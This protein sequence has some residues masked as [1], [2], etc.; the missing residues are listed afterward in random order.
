LSGERGRAY[1]LLMSEP[2]PEPRAYC[3][4]CDALM[5]VERPH[6]GIVF[7][8]RV[9]IGLVAIC[10]IFAPLFIADMVLMLPLMSG[11]ALAGPTLARLAGEPTRCK[12]C[13][14]DLDVYGASASW[15]AHRDELFGRGGVD[16]DGGVED[17]LGGAGLH[18]HGEALDD[19]AGVGADHVTPDHAIRL[20]VHDELHHGALLDIGERELERTEV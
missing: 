10:A 20:G 15:L 18:R 11:V 7:A 3:P 14:L 9:W 1:P 4:R 6:R 19:L 16:A 2:R 12:W 13:R 8:H 17:R 5:E